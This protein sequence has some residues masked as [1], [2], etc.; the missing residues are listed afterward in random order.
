MDKLTTLARCEGYDD[1]MDMLQ[2]YIIES[3]VPAICTNP[4][5]NYST[6]YEPDQTSGWCELC[7]GNSV[8]SCLILAGIC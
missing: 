5:C 7:G 1:P 2:D 6:Y 3:T 4:D 8:V